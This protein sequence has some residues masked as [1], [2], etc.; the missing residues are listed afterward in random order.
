[1]TLKKDGHPQAVYLVGVPVGVK[2]P[3]G[4]IEGG[5]YVGLIKAF[6]PEKQFGFIECPELFEAYGQNTWVC[7][8]QLKDFQPGQHVEFTMTLNR[9]GKPQAQDLG[10]VGDANGIIKRAR[11]NG[12]AGVRYSGTLKELSTELGCGIIDCPDLLAVYGCDTLVHPA[13][14]GNFQPGQAIE[15]TMS[16]NTDGGHPWAIELAEKRPIEKPLDTPPWL[17]PQD[18][19]QYIGTIKQ[20][21]PGKGF[22]F[23]DCP[24]L[25]QQYNRDT[26]VHH[27]QMR[28]FKVGDQVS[29]QM[30]L[31]QVGHPQGINLQAVTTGHSFG[32]SSGFGF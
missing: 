8:Q 25:R 18:G 14:V 22:G 2:R 16:T 10:E 28:D 6:L 7:A 17:Q 31:N 20:Y 32:F 15:F 24:V 4:G 13:Q 12:E 19:K 3:R 27:A 21:E 29:F 26:W 11:K 1:M 30:A 5:R 9:N 23:I